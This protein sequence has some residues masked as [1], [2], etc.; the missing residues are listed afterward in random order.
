MKSAHIVFGLLLAAGAASAQQYTISTVAGIG[1]AQGYYGD[2][3]AAT[4]ALL[5]FPF[6]VAVDSKGNFYIADYYSFIVREVSGGVI[7]TIAGDL[8]PGFQGDNG[9]G[10]QAQ[11]RYVRGLA[12]DA[13]GN[14]YIA[15]TSNNR[16]RKVSP[17]GTI[18]APTGTISTFA[19]NG[20]PGYAGDGGTAVNAELNSPAG[21][22][23][24]SAGNVYIAD[25]GNSTVRK[26]DTK[27]NITTVAGTGTWGY[28]GD[29]GPASKAMVASPEAVAIDTA[30]D[31]YIADSGNTDIR[32]IT[33]DGNIHT[34]VSN[35]DAESI[36]VDAAGSIYFPNYLNSTVQKIL[37][38]GTQFTIAGNGTP[39]FSGDG[40]PATGAQLNSP[41]GVALDSSGNVYVADFANM[42]IRL[43]T[44]VSS[45][46]SVVNAASGVGLAISPGE[47]VAIYGTGLG[48][49]TPASQQVINGKFGT[50]LAGTTVTFNGISAP[51]LYTSATQVNA[52]VPYAM[53]TAAMAD[54]TLNYQGQSFTA[55]GVPIV[56]SAPGIFTAG[57]G[58][59]AAIN[60][61]GS[62][63]SMS[64]PARQGSAVSLY[65]TGEG[66]TNPPGVD[67]QITP[68]PPAPAIIPLAPFTIYLSGQ[69]A[70]SPTFPGGVEAPGQVAGV[71]QINVQIPTNLIQTSGTGPVAVPVLINL[72]TSF[73]QPG[74]TIAV[75][76]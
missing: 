73:T 44:P 59:A 18:A 30:G 64:N 25:Y 40:G 19:G 15:D 31:I 58:Q 71:M 50:Q 43:L 33:P 3:G 7:N 60:Q 65:L 11:I 9:P 41:Y 51:I 56:A 4:A 57:G 20:T 75:A 72:G 38:N 52:I 54:V 67:G 76:P 28:S 63:N 36:A 24:D 21:L 69:G 66:L 61:D 29:G 27:G 16:I 39:G 55:A 14:L 17:G 2:T 1:T 53:A 22:A 35:V 74:V 42:A 46:I 48:P 34:I 47:L 10:N 32:E 45:S 37:S 70:G 8:T 13:A 23:V 6:K 49:A 68:L 5:D 12:V 62:V 26:V